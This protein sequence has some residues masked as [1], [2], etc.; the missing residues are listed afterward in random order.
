MGLGVLL[1]L[2]WAV[3]SPEAINETHDN[4]TKVHYY[5]SFD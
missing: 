2:H 5:A 3:S 4:T 1:A